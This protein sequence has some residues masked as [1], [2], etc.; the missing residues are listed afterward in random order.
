MAEQV[1]VDIALEAG[2]AP[3]GVDL[4]DQ[5]M[6]GVV[7]VVLFAAA[8]V[9]DA[10]APRHGVVGEVPALALVGGIAQHTPLGAVLVPL[11]A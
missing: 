7:Q 10:V 9:G 2:T 5:M 8:G 11:V 4:F 6:V 3:G 1:A